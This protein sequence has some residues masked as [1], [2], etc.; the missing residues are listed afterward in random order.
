MKYLAI[1]T[2]NFL[3]IISGVS[4]DYTRSLGLVGGMTSGVSLKTFSTD[5]QAFEVILSTKFR[6]LK[7]TGLKAWHRPAMWKQT[8]KL[9]YIFG[10]GSHAGFFNKYPKNRLFPSYNTHVRKNTSYAVIGLDAILG[11]E[12][13][14]IRYPL[15]IGLEYKPFFDLFGPNYFNLYLGDFSLA[16][17]Y[18]F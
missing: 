17:R 10:Y 9:F 11:I 14:V 2:I 5:E 6:G 1:V 18:T 15:V 3:M 12:Y 7:I 13:R 4:Q 8:D 16:V